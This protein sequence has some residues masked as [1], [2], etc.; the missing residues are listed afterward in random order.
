MMTN[1]LN[2]TS[3]DSASKSKTT[4]VEYQ[5]HSW[6]IVYGW[7]WVRGVNYSDPGLALDAMHRLCS[8]VPAAVI[9]SNGRQ[10]YTLNN[11]PALNAEKV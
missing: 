3:K 7:N 10:I 1:K 9:A 4:N 5:V 6:N 11:P 2:S 8:D